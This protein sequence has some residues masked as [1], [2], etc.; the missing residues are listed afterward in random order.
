MG[1]NGREIYSTVSCTC[2][3]AHKTF[4][5]TDLTSTYSVCTRKGLGSNPREDMDVYKCILPSQHGGTIN[6]HE[7]ASPLVR[8]VEGEERWEASDD[9]LGFFPQ[10]WGGAEQNSIVICM[11]LKAKKLTTSLKI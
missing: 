9:L 6:N 7:V 8:S 1:L 11:V 4:G 10:N 3:S 2:D 5:P